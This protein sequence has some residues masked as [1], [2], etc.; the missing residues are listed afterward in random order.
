[1]GALAQVVSL[2]HFMAISFDVTLAVAWLFFFL[3]M[4]DV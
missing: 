4:L 2:G 3:P 1:M